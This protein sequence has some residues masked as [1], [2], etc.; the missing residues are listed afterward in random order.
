LTGLAIDTSGDVLSVALIHGSELHQFEVDAGHRHSEQLLELVNAVIN[1][2]RIDRTMINFVACMRG[3]GSFTGLRIGMSAVKGLAT[4]LEIPFYAVS[5]FDCM[6]SS[7]SIWPGTVLTLIDAKQNR[8]YAAAFKDGRRI[9]NDIDA[10]VREIADILLKTGGTSP[11]L[12]CGTDAPR[13]RDII[14]P[15]VPQLSLVVDPAHRRG[16]SREL[17]TLAAARAESGDRGETDE[18]GLEYLRKS[19]AEITRENTKRER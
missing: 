6:A 2:S 4:A 1:I 3:P 16:A 10:D 17:A 18:I 19:E 8:W 13:A 9:C 15:M 11:I 7:R 12:V 14:A 5:T